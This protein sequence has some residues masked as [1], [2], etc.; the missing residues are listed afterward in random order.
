MQAICGNA[1][2][3]NAHVVSLG[4]LGLHSSPK[5]TVSLA[6]TQ[7]TSSIATPGAALSP[8]A[9]NPLTTAHSPTKRKATAQGQ[10]QAAPAQHQ[11]INQ[12]SQD[13]L[14][15][16]AAAGST[17]I[18]NHAGDQAALLNVQPN[19]HKLRKC[20]DTRFDDIE[21]SLAESKQDNA[22]KMAT[23]NEIKGKLATSGPCA[24]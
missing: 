10:R 24:D 3:L 16:Q 1:S 15:P 2:A 7:P 22:D 4:D 5:H 17:T 13:F 19:Y 18:N 11:F 12:I 23:L 21:R 9:L 8:G 14:P 6:P 20:L